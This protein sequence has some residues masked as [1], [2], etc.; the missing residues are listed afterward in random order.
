MQKMC[1]LRRSL[2][3]LED[4]LTAGE[5]DYYRVIAELLIDVQKQ[6]AYFQ[7]YGAIPQVQQMGEKL[8]AIES[9]LKRQVQWSFREIGQL[10]VAD[11]PDEGFGL[12]A[13]DKSSS[14]NDLSSLNRIYLVVDALGIHFRKDLLERFAQLQL[15]PYEKQFAC[16]AGNK[17]SSMEHLD[18]RFAWFKKLLSVVDNRLSTFIP[19]K[20]GLPTTLF[21]E[22]VRRTKQHIVDSLTMLEKSSM[23]TATRVQVLLRAV[24]AVVTFEAEMK[25]SFTMAARGL[26][27]AD[28]SSPTPLSNFNPTSATGSS[29]SNNSSSN[30][31]KSTD[32]GSSL[33]TTLGSECIADAFDEFLGPYVQSERDELD[34]IMSKVNREEEAGTLVE[35]DG[36]RKPKDP[37]TSSRKLFE[38]VKKSLKS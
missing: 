30:S 1:T 24:K 33:S 11:G 34:K 38:F 36:P 31:N 3:E 13:S 8:R 18:R 37:F 6:F 21:T 5:S 23:D 22:F 29:G 25:V 32:G 19:A 26:D 27:D 7:A 28:G 9:E 2:R 17:F 35:E 15:I 12:N 16:S 10:V 20:W 14:N 4:E